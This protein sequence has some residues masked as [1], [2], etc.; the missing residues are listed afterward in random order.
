MPSHFA[1]DLLP[2]IT[3]SFV[4]DNTGSTSKILKLLNLLPFS[5]DLL[6][7]LSLF[8]NSP[9]RF[10]HF[11]PMFSILINLLTTKLMPT[12]STIIPDNINKGKN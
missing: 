11:K 4:Q 1:S 5:L 12:P 6:N 2:K 3:Q 8:L 7:F 10:I 9:Q